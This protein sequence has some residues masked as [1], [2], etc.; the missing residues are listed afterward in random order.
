M[1]KSTVGKHWAHQRFVQNLINAS[2]ARDLADAAKEWSFHKLYVSSEQQGCQLCNTHINVCVTL[3][4][5]VNGNFLVLG[6]DCY[7]KLLAFLRK[8]RVE[9]V[10]PSRETQTGE[11]RRYWKKVADPL[12]NRTVVGWL[13]TE[14][15]SG[16][17]EGDIAEVVYTITRIGFAP[18]TGDADKVVAFYKATR[19]F[20]IDD[21]IEGPDLWYFRHKRLLPTITIDQIERVQKMLEK[22]KALRQVI[23]KRKKAEWK[24]QSAKA[25]VRDAAQ[26]VQNLLDKV[27]AAAERGVQKADKAVV[28][29]KKALADISALEEPARPLKAEKIARTAIS[30]W[31]WYT[32]DPETILSVK[33][34]G[35][36]YILVNRGNRWN[37]IWRVERFLAK[38]V[39]SMT[40]LY[41]AH[42]IQAGRDTLV[43]LQEQLESSDILA[44]FDFTEPSR[45]VQGTFV[46]KFNGKIVLSSRGI[47]NPGNYL[48]FILGDE[49]RYYRA[50]V[51][52]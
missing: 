4:N 34:P 11:L 51:I 46:A 6:E 2:Q 47:T 19:R 40:G 18:T 33:M 29:L 31:Q 41:K 30:T 38:D 15:K 22:D 21:L 14:L 32:T 35:K 24:R 9:S 25:R 44:K 17:I 45:Q 52:G 36:S 12:H 50:W 1:N 7:D 28:A 27:R 49:G 13:R 42:V 16:H 43:R 23:F 48:A 5:N 37:A 20:A 10:L 8:G 3:K 26:E 39:V